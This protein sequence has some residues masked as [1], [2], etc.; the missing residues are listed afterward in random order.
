VAGTDQARR[1]TMTSAERMAA[2]VSGDRP[3][4]IPILPF[5]GGF[6]AQIVGYPIHTIYDDPERS[7]WAQMWAQELLG[8]DGGPSFWYASYGGWEFGGEI[9]MP[10]SELEQ[11]PVVTRF[12][13]QTPEEVDALELPDVENAGSFPLHIE[14]ARIQKQFGMPVAVPAWGPFTAAANIV[15]V[16]VLCRW[17]LKRPEAAH[18]LLSKVVVFAKKVIDCFVDLFSGHALSGSGGCATSSN[19]I[20]SPGQFEE[21]VLPYHREVY[22][23]LSDRGVKTVFCHICGDQTQNLSYWAEVPFGERGILSFGDEV[24]LTRAM[25][26]FGEKHIVAGNVEPRLIAEGTWLDVY[27]SA[28]ACIDQAKYAYGGYILMAGC[29][30]PPSSPPYNI[31]ALKKAVMDFGFYD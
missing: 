27:E 5:T 6:C 26:V 13:V 1:E 3:D 10:R 19:Q 18:A 30:I 9:K 21:F 20:I 28:R 15:G 29:D 25:E 22:G 16:D 23:H 12:P 24:D 4:R 7:F 17:M 14:F 2:I 31:Y 11:A 8:Y